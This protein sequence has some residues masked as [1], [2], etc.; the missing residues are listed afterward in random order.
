MARPGNKAALDTIA[1]SV[2]WWMDFDKGQRDKEGIETTDD[3]HIYSPPTWPSYGMLKNWV[4]A[5]EDACD[6]LSQ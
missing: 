3:T 6:Q 2:Q 1:K 5:L 4:A